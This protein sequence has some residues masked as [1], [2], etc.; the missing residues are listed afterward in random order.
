M[1]IYPATV[2]FEHANCIYCICFVMYWN[3]PK[4][5]FF[6]CPCHMLPVELLAT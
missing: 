5:I 1:Y 3:W 6:W 2:L 4:Y